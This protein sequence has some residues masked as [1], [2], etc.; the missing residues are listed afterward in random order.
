MGHKVGYVHRPHR[1][2]LGFWPRVRANR[3]YPS[4]NWKEHSEK[5]CAGF[6]AYKA[7]M[8]HAMIID[9][10]KNSPTKGKKVFTPV[11]ILETPPIKVIGVRFYKDTP[12][13]K[14]A[15]GE[16]ITNKPDKHLKRKTTTSK[17]KD[18]KKFTDYKDYDDIRLIIQT[19]PHL[20]K[21]KKTPEVF[22]MGLGG[23][24]EEKKEYAQSVYEKEVKISDVLKEGAQVDTNGVTK[25]KGT[26]GSVKRHG[27]TI[28]QHKSEKTKRAAGSLAPMCPRKVAWQVPQFGQMGYQSR[29]EYNK[30]VLKISDKPEEISVKGGLKGYGQVKGDYLIIKGSVVG[31][32][33]RMVILRKAIRGNKRLPK[34]APQIKYLSLESNQGGRK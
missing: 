8:T 2:S 3:Q 27:V 14:K 19:Q 24:L 21:L 22:E 16:L 30:W 20:I 11:T 26:Q 17:K 34:V 13:G 33:K 10:R 1:S 23:S 12:Y 25:G 5:G 9:N 6:A 31:S 29:V 18:V 32:K 15:V 28:R 4:V 7:G